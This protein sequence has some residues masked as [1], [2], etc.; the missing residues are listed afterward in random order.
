MDEKIG[1]DKEVIEDIKDKEIMA[2]G[3][4][5]WDLIPQNMVLRRVKRKK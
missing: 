4:P 5:Q 3:L 1:K 2:K